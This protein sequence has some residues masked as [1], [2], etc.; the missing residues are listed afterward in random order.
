MDATKS[1]Q[2]SHH[3]R[4]SRRKK[5]VFVSIIIV[6]I[7][8][9]VWGSFT[10]W[11]RDAGNVALEWFAWAK[12]IAPFSTAIVATAAGLIALVSYR[13]RRLADDRAEWWR[14]AQYALDLIM[15][16]SEQLGRKPGMKLLDHLVEDSKVTSRDAAMLK[17]AVKAIADEVVAQEAKKQQVKGPVLAHDSGRGRSILDRLG[18]Q[19][20]GRRWRHGSEETKHPRGEGSSVSS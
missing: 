15:V 20:Q 19:Q 2:A 3:S 16:D 10:G 9:L 12:P 14:R 6:V 13:Q 17:N 4:F 8:L 5:A 11:V 1:D 7:G 18:F